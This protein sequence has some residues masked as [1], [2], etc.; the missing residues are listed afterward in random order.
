VL[1]PQP[2]DTISREAYRREKTAM[3]KPTLTRA[4]LDRGRERYDI[5]C[6]PCHA[7][8]GSGYGSVVLRG[9][10]HPKSFDSEDMRR[11]RD[12]HLYDVISK[13]YG[14]MYPLGYKIAPK[15]RWA[16]VAYLRAL[17]LSQSAAAEDLPPEAREKI[18][19]KQ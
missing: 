4:L 12:D 5:F 8:T 7:K 18:G 15:D 6:S 19:Q 3:Q 13:G 16:I 1:Q 10:P 9:M 11:A 17:Q 2:K 14:L